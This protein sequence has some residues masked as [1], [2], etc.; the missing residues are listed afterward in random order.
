MVA[1]MIQNTAAATRRA[2]SASGHDTMSGKF[3]EFI[4]AEVLPA[5]ETHAA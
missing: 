1:V 5:V 2:R 4:E 3:A